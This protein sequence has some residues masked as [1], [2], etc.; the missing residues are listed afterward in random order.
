[1]ALID[2]PAKR[3]MRRRLRRQQQSAVE[4][5]QQADQHIEK[6]LIKRFERLISVRR[7]ILLWTC[8]VMLLIFCQILQLRALSPYYQ[9]LRPAA[10]GIFSEGLV[11]TFTNANPIYASGVADTAVSRLVFS[12][13]F[14]YD[15]RNHLVGDLAQYYNLEHDHKTYDVT[16]KKNIVWQDG[17]P[18]TADDV[19]FTYRTIQKP[20][21]QS[22]LNSSWE[23]ITITKRGPYQVRFSLPDAL[24]AFP[25][26]LTNGIVPSHLLSGIPASQLRSTA[27]NTDPVGTGPFKWQ[28]VEVS[29]NG[30]PDRVQKIGLA[31]NKKYYAGPS[32]LDGFSVVTFTDEPHLLSAFNK[33]QINAMSGLESLPDKLSNKSD[34]QVKVTPL[35]SIVMAFYNNSVPGLDDEKVRQALTSAVDRRPLVELS[36]YPTNLVDSP[37]LPGQV[38]YDSHTRQPSFNLKRAKQLLQSAGWRTDKHGQRHKGHRALQFTLRTQDTRDYTQAARYL[39]KSWEAIGVKVDVRY[40]DSNEL[41]RSVIA[42]HDYDILL[43]GINVGTDPDVFAYWDSSQASVSSSGHLNLSEYKSTAADQALEAGRTRTNKTLRIV[44]YKAF[45]QQWRRDAPALALFQP[46]LLYVTRGTIYNYDRAADNGAADRYY[47]VQ[48]WMIR[49]TRQTL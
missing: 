31:A 28:F 12:G 39:Q 10:G 25:Y 3:K 38:G 2:E 15:N 34:V 20:E 6:L 17:Q 26:A 37:L 19:V 21:A 33:K 5:G 47:N 43:Y 46:N 45:Q 18:F 41:Q 4:F 29:A 9:D 1:M 22:P 23:G 44:K 49:Q 14:K 24:A 32:Q 48:D 36:N 13:L 30:S 27:F 7:F 8:L 16:L 35:T 40:S 42:N 11:G